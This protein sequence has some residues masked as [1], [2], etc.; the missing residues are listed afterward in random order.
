MVIYLSG[1]FLGLFMKNNI[2]YREA[3]HHCYFLL[4]N[5]VFNSFVH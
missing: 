1:V 5:M 2:N 4:V 3:L